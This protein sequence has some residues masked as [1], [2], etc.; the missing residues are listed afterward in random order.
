MLTSKIN[1]TIGLLR[2]LQNHLP[3]L[4]SITVYK[5][6]VRPHLDYGDIIY[7]ETYNAPFHQKLELCQYNTCPAITKTI[8]STSADKINKRIRFGVPSASPLVQKTMLF[9]QDL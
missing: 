3:R 4:A 2:K 7:D 6:F 1:K 9:L 8:R 5:S